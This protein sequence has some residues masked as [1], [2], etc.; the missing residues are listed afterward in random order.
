M[1]FYNVKFVPKYIKN[2]EVLLLLCFSVIMLIWFEGKKRAPSEIVRWI[3]Y[4]SPL[5][6]FLRMFSKSELN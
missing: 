6:N 1:R 3:Y 5:D 4:G 2:C